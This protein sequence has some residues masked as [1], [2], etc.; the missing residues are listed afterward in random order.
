MAP[1][2]RRPDPGSGGRQRALSEVLGVALMVAI[3]VLLA[4]VTIAMTVTMSQSRLDSAAV[5]DTGQ[6]AFDVEDAEDLQIRAAHRSGVGSDVDFVMA[7]NSEPVHRW[8]GTGSLTVECLYPGDRVVI[9]TEDGEGHSRLVLDHV[10]DHATTCPQYNT[11]PEKFAHVVVEGTA[12]EVNERYA[13]GMAVDP[14]GD[15]VATDFNGG[16]DIQLGK[17][18][19]ANRWHY[20]KLYDREIEGLE[21]PVFVMVLVDNVHWTDVP[22][23]AAHPEVPAGQQYN[24]TDA[25]PAGLT[26]GADSYTLNDGTIDPN[27]VP[28]TEP[29]N[30]VFMVFK[31]GCES[32]TLR[33]IENTAGYSNRI[34]LNDTVIIDDAST[35]S[36]GQTFSAP[37]VPCRG[38]ASW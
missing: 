4:G 31:P 13:F 14:N 23:P 32:S 10:F 21:P 26:T 12:Y 34:Y 19:L 2:Q 15:S 1:W 25:P 7:V 5:H 33:F 38:D 3:V 30:D 8:D 17:V 28:A 37:G 35:A 27:S 6:Y 20:V 36:P 18:S 11:F 16:N 9:R 24:W 29:T 22:D